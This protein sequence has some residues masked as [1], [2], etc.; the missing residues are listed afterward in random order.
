MN[1]KLLS[2]KIDLEE[3]KL[4]FHLL[5]MDVYLKTGQIEYDKNELSYRGV[6]Y[7]IEKGKNPLQHQARL[8]GVQP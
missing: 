1:E 7:R 5:T 2:L 3:A 4:K 6:V 8:R